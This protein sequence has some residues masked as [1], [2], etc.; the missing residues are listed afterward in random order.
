MLPRD[1]E[2]RGTLCGTSDG[3]RRPVRV[4]ISSAAIE[5]VVCG[6]EV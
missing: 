6:R 1:S 3:V 2:R 4:A 5:E